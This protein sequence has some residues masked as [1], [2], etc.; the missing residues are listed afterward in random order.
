MSLHTYFRESVS[1]LHR[2]TWPTREQAFKIVAITLVF[3][4]IAAL[5]FGVLDQVL[6]LGYSYLL[7]LAGIA[8]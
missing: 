3:V 2:V 4:A 8:K 5:I 7:N 6:A 1:E